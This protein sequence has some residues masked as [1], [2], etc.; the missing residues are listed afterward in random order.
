[1]P[2]NDMSL[3]VFAVLAGVV[4]WKLWSVL[5]TRT[6]AERPPTDGFRPRSRLGAPAPVTTDQAKESAKEPAA[7]GNVVRL[8][9]SDGRPVGDPRRWAPLAQPGTPVARGLDA[10]AAA[11][12]HF[13]LPEFLDG[14]KR[15][16]EAVLAAFAA[17]DRATL[18]SLLADD[19]F[20]AFCADVEAREKRG[21][22]RK[23]AFVGVDRAEI[24]DAHLD[25][26][27]AQIAL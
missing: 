13:V 14:A 4:I 10:I 2:A 25:G 19:V 22:T 23:T 18:R 27:E 21:E 15:A 17:G 5:G 8:Q 26:R 7:A 9:S 20:A 16:Y 3:L 24:A 6:G 1:M 11:D 12:P